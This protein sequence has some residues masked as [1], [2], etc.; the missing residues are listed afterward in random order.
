MSLFR[1]CLK[2]E[3]AARLT[4]EAIL[5]SRFL[6]GRGGWEMDRSTGVVVAAAATAV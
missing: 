4:V 1:G 5:G 2:V 3:V 6:N